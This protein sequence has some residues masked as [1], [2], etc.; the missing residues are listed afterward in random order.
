MKDV[1]AARLAISLARTML[2]TCRGMEYD[3]AGYSLKHIAVIV[4]SLRSR[5][6]IRHTERYDHSVYIATDDDTGDTSPFQ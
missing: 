6:G 1:L 3:L 5:S 4:R 2:V